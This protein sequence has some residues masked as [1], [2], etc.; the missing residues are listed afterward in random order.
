MSTFNHDAILPRLLERI[1]KTIFEEDSLRIE[2]VQEVSV[3]LSSSTLVSSRWKFWGFGPEIEE[4]FED[5]FEEWLEERCAADA[6]RREIE[7]AIIEDRHFL[8]LTR[9]DSVD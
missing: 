9:E 8:N 7:R 2:D 5:F 1:F 6:R 4:I 3:V